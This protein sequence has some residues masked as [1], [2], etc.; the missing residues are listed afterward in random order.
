MALPIITTVTIGSKN[1]GIQSS[2]G[3]H[4][5]AADGLMGGQ[6]GIALDG[7][8][9][10]GVWSSINDEVGSGSLGWASQRVRRQLFAPI[11]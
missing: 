2:L 4:V 11:V 1:R 5:F 8:A 7:L 9:N 3:A 6:V 10:G